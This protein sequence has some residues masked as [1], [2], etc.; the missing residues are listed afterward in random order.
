MLFRSRLR[1]AALR[2]AR[3][4]WPVL[5]ESVVD[6]SQATVDPDRIAA[7][8]PRTGPQQAVCLPTGRTF[9]VLDV[10]TVLGAH[11]VRILE[12]GPRPY[13]AA[14]RTPDRWL[15]FTAPLGGHLA[16]GPALTWDPQ[17]DILHRGPGG[18]VTAPPSP[19][20]GHW[21]W[22][23]ELRHHCLPSAAAVLEALTAAHQL[24]TS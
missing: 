7:W 13:P 15:F 1:S 12:C 21:V 22:H 18:I 17:L 23:W 19:G 4:S 6:L 20:A 5:P 14:I 9:D 8:W 24:A 11:A 16:P 10:S 2:Y 3:G